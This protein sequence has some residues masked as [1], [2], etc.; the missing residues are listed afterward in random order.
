M[1]LLLD[2]LYQAFSSF[3]SPMSRQKCCTCNG[4]NA[5]CVGCRCARSKVKCTSCF[6]L[7]H[8]RC[9]NSNSDNLSLES[10]DCVSSLLSI[11]A[12]GIPSTTHPDNQ[13]TLTVDE[14]LAAKKE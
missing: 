2:F 6:P 11:E 12:E 7:R 8:G 10:R 3:A 13:E 14:I 9:N 1:I 4:V 5:K